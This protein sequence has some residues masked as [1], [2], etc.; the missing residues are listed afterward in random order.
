MKID[1]KLKKIG[2][3]EKQELTKEEKESVILKVTDLLI[4]AFPILVQEKSNIIT[5]LNQTNMHYAKIQKNLSN[6]NYIYENGKIYFSED[7]NINNI[8]DTIIHEIIHYLQDVRKK[9]GKL[10]KIG[11]CNFNELSIKGLGMNEAGVQYISSKAISKEQTSIK[12]YNLILK[13]IS[14][15][16]YPIIT[17]LIEQI[18]A[19]IGEDELVMAVIKNDSKFTDTFFNTFEGNGQSIIN[20]FDNIIQLNNESKNEKNKEEITSL[21]IETQDIIMKT[22]FEKTFKLIETE[23][24][25]NELSEKLNKYVTI[26]GKVERNGYTYNNCEIFKSY[27]ANKLD[28][29]MINLCKSK[30]KTALAIV[31]GGRINRII[32]KIRSYFWG[33]LP[34]T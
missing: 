31:Y 11:L 2:I 26:A 28:K 24:D 6:V 19:L 9:N 14:P 27:M 32:Q 13:T 22:Y 25:V 15:T 17:N 20:N 12:K 34:K 33:N 1:K 30:N 18:I 3:E 29:K 23:D 8:T 7:I 21:Y 5:K 16:Y 10:G 4:N